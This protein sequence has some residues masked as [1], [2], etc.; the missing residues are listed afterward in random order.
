MHNNALESQRIKA[1]VFTT[2]TAKGP[3]SMCMHNAKRDAFILAPIKLSNGNFW[4][5]LEGRERA[6]PVN[7]STL[8]LH[9]YGLKRSKGRARQALMEQ[10]LVAARSTP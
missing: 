8:N 2:M 1:C 7:I 6:Q 10:R 3:I 5:P 4:Q 9:D